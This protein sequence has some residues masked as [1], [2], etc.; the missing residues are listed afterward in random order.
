MKINEVISTPPK[1]SLIEDVCAPQAIARVLGLPYD[2]VHQACV[3]FKLWKPRFGMT[4]SQIIAAVRKLGWDIR[5]HT[6]LTFVRRKDKTTGTEFYGSATL[7][8]VLKRL[9]PGKKYL[10]T[11]RNHVIAYADG[12]VHDDSN[13]G[14]KHRVHDVLEIVTKGA[15]SST[16]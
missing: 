11:L 13:Y 4:T 14:K 10:I 9:D 16:G 15:G 7:N 12:Q 6:N 3:N 5:S 1:S 8:Q 2:D